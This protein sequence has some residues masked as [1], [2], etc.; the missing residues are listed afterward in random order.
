MRGV[1]KK[2]IV[3]VH[4]FLLL[5]PCL[6]TKKCL[7]THLCLHVGEIVDPHNL[8]DILIDL[9]IS[10]TPLENRVMLY[11]K[12]VHSYTVE[13]SNSPPRYTDNAL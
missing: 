6:K 10:E 5:Y 7:V 12:V 3:G 1:N 4:L 9:Q 13:P 11:V 8:L 2:R